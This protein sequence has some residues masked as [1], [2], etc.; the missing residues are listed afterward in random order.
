MTDRKDSLS[1]LNNE[2]L[3]EVV[4]NYR[5]YNYDDI[6]RNEAIE[7]LEERG[8]D[9][10]QLIL[11]GNFENQTYNSAERAFNSFKRNSIITIIFYIVIFITTIFS[12]F[13]TLDY[14]PLS[15]AILSINLI[16][17]IFYFVFF[18]KTFINQINFF[19]IIGKH[20]G[21]K[22]TI[23][24]FFLGVPLFVFLYLY[25]RNEMNEELKLIE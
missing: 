1:S 3:I 14:D 15:L 20:P 25:Y 9:K 4:K 24:Y 5:K 13:F 6:V 2:K 7:I 11:T 8:I 10:K 16:A 18:V 23:I 21:S 19:D 12:P 22:N 17:I